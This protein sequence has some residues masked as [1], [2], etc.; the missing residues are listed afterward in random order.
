MKLCRRLPRI[1]LL[2]ATYF[3]TVTTAQRKRW[4]SDPACAEALCQLICAERGR[5]YLLHAFVVMPDHY[6]L[7]ITL[8]DDHRLPSVVG[9]I[10]SLAARRVNAL[11]GRRGP[12]WSRRF[13]DHVVRNHEDLRECLGYIHD[14]P[15]A[16]GLVPAAPDYLYS[17]A[18]FFEDLPSPWGE[19]DLAW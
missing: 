11:V 14:N 10:N 18:S 5:A 1:D 6:H 8:L 4:F 9:R 17:S 12:I 16:S 19:F 15:R 2:N 13:Y 3:A 7:L